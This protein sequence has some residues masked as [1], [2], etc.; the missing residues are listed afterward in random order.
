[1]LSNLHA[2]DSA[3]RRLLCRFNLPVCVSPSLALVQFIYATLGCSGI[4]AGAPR[5]TQPRGLR[6]DRDIAALI[7]PAFVR[8]E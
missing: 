6:F 3:V 8:H 1:M 2:S 4:R 7:S 5:L